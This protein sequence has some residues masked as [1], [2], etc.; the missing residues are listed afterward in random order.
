MARPVDLGDDGQWDIRLEAVRLIKAKS[1][2]SEL[3]ALRRE[4][5]ALRAE[6][7]EPVTA[8]ASAGGVDPAGSK[9]EQDTGTASHF[10]IDWDEVKEVVTD[11]ARELGEATRERP[12]LGMAGAFIL[13]LLV[14]RM[15]S[16]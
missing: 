14:G 5:E 12:V 8:A 11:L 3:A 2:T 7:R 4:V 9:S 10:D 1:T 6:R 15:V 16:R 13:G